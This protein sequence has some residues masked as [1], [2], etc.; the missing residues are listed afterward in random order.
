MTNEQTNKLKLITKILFWIIV[1]V[2]LFVIVFSF[3]Y[4]GIDKTQGTIQVSDQTAIDL[5]R[6]DELT[7]EDKSIY[8]NRVLFDV[9]YYSNNKQNGQ[10]LT[11][12]RINYFENNTLTSDAYR[13]TGFQYIGD[14]LAMC[15][16]VR[17]RDGMTVHN[18]LCAYYD[19]TMDVNYIG[20]LGDDNVKIAH[21]FDNNETFIIKIDNKP[22]LMEYTAKTKYKILGI[23]TKIESAPYHNFFQ[24]VVNAVK[25]NDYKFGDFYLNIPVEDFFTFYAYAE[26]GKLEEKTAD[27]L[28]EYVV[29]KIHYNENGMKQASQSFF[30]MIYGDATY[31]MTTKTNTEYWTAMNVYHINASDLSYRYSDI[32][33]GSF[34]YLSATTQVKFTD[35]KNYKV[36]LDLNLNDEYLTKN[37]INLLGIDISAFEGFEID[38]VNI[39]SNSY[40]EF[41]I[42]SDA[43]KNS[44]LKNLNKTNNIVLHISEDAINSEYI[45]GSL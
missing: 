38:T 8:E 14:Y 10:E 29:I 17:V 37:N 31:G 34:A 42:L 4:A 1:G 36:V 11:E 44:K 7:S 35:L 28:N 22:Y 15:K 16:D 18:M 3:V 24:Y 26:D 19:K 13:S 41:Y 25:N 27:Y 20:Y 39:S 12:F 5:K 32:Q 6:E 43:F 45:G 33:G 30:N 9:N 23:F 21:C 2:A 40:K